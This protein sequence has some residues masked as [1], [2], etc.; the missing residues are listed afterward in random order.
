MYFD[1]TSDM[2]ESSFQFMKTHIFL[3]IVLLSFHGFGATPV[4]S[5]KLGNPKTC[6]GRSVCLCTHPKGALCPFKQHVS[7]AHSHAAESINESQS[8]QGSF[9]VAP[10]HS[11]QPKIMKIIAYAKSRAACN[12]NS[13]FAFCDL[14]SCCRYS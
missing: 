11:N 1:F 10:C 5:G 4:F 3:L 8:G 2:V 9:K 13:F 14:G 6:C 12:L 7:G